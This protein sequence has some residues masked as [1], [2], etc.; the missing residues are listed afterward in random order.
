MAMIIGETT[1]NKEQY[2]RQMK[3]GT[4]AYLGRGNKYR[5][6]VGLNSVSPD[7]STAK[8]Y[9]LFNWIDENAAQEVSTAAG[10]QLVRSTYQSNTM[11]QPYWTA[12]ASKQELYDYA[13]KHTDSLGPKYNEIMR[14]TPVDGMLTPPIVLRDLVLKELPNRRV[15]LAGDAAHPMTPFRKSQ[16]SL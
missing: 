12:T 4:S 3:L 14:L 5:I 7:A 11:Q 9:W 13:M 16:F 8:Y 2:E 1:L 15:T 10:P 6:F